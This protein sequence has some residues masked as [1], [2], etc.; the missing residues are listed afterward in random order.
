ML[1]RDI[2][3]PTYFD[4]IFWSKLPRV[5]LADIFFTNIDRNCFFID[6]NQGFFYQNQSRF[7]T[8]EDNYGFCV[9]CQLKLFFVWRQPEPFFR[10]DLP[11][12]LVWHQPRLFFGRHQL[13]FFNRHWLGIFL[14]LDRGWREF[15]LDNV[16]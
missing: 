15:F 3:L 2:F 6:I 16:D 14:P 10:R 12:D 11:E 9:Q 4:A 1:E 5:F 7:F 13:G 8:A